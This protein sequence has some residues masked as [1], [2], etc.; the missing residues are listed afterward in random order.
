VAC[1]SCASRAGILEGL[2]LK[3]LGPQSEDAPQREQPFAIGA[4]HV[5]HR[6][7]AHPMPVQPNAAVEGETHPLAAAREL[8]IGTLYWQVIRPS[9]VAGGTGVAAPENSEQIRPGA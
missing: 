5:R 4:H 1:S 6:L 3:P 9:T 2:V 7:A 8:P